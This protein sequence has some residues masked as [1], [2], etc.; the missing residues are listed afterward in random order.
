MKKN[1]VV[2][3]ISSDLVFAV[4]NLMFDI[5][6]L[7]QD[8]ADE[9]VVLHDGGLKKKDLLLLNSILPTREIKYNI[10]VDDL[11]I[12]N[13]GTLKYFTIMAYAKFECIR[14]LEEYKNIIYLDPDMVIVGNLSILLSKCESGVKF[15]PGNLKVSAQLHS[16]INEYNMEEEG[17]CGCIFVFQDHL[18]NYKD[19]YDFCISSLNKYANKLYL[20]EQAIF[21]IMIQEHK[22]S[23]CELDRNIYSPHPTEK[24]FLSNAKIIHAY[25]QPKFWNGLENEQWN[26]NY[27]K[28]IE[29]GGSR[30]KKKSV[31]AKVKNKMLNI[32]KRLIK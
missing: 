5:K 4:A 7:S 25:G 3:T 16:D 2:F 29:M 14:L 26:Q 24:Q 27:K 23:Y 6:R 12:F 1:A 20:A 18:L 21:D 19:M 31:I 28:W 30:Y 17:I 22:I 11:S 8:I 13:Q 9:V 32:F 15:M 10:P